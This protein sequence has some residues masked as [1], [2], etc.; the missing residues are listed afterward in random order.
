MEI[1]LYKD[2]VER[3][4]SR[5]I[6]TGEGF[7]VIDQI[8]RNPENTLVFTTEFRNKLIRALP[9]HLRDACQRW[10]TKLA[11]AGRKQLLPKKGNPDSS[12]DED[13]KSLLE[14]SPSEFAIGLTY[15]S[16]NLQNQELSKR[17]CA[18]SLIQKLNR[19]WLL[20]ELAA[21]HPK[22]ITV[23]SDDF[24]KDSNVDQ[25]FSVALTAKKTLDTVLLF[26]RHLNINH[27][28][29][30]A[31]KKYDR[32]LIY[33]TADHDKEKFTQ[34][35]KKFKNLEVYVLKDHY[36]LHGRNI[37]SGNLVVW[38]DN[39]FQNLKAGKDHDWRIGVQLCTREAGRFKS[40]CAKF[41]L[42]TRT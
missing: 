25:F 11:D 9:H 26:D 19:H 40:A 35:K 20:A 5:E 28:K 6:T 8:L 29:L 21:N 39:D 36:K 13:F 18:I 17:V 16:V 37:V 24:E 10:F 41:T 15:N 38:T 22:P 30:D 31:L 7:S 23:T 1:V 3:Y 33:T 4:L 34:L 14:D 32:I 27:E 2:L 12:F 42:I